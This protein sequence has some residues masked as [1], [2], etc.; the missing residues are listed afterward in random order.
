M[1]TTSPAINNT[2]RKYFSDELVIIIKNT[3]TQVGHIRMMTNYEYLSLMK[4][5][6]KIST[7]ILYLSVQS[8]TR[9]QRSKQVESYLGPNQPVNFSYWGLIYVAN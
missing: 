7:S 2:F 5:G 6:L 1:Y 4:G 8:N 3:A 9:K